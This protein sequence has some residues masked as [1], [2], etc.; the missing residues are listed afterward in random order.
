VMS[1]HSQ[2]VPTIEND[3][4]PAGWLQ[5]LGTD[6][7]I[8]AVRVVVPTAPVCSPRVSPEKPWTGGREATGG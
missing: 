3:V 7:A 1:K 8:G 2:P 6:G 4:R 5:R